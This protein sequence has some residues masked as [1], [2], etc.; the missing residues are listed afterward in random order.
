MKNTKI[1]LLA[2]V[3]VVALLTGVI[4][5]M[6][7]ATETTPLGYSASRVVKKDTTGIT[8]IK[9][10]DTAS[11]KTEYVVSDLDGLNK[12]ATVVTGGK[13]L[14]GVTIYQTANI[15]GKGLG[16]DGANAPFAGIGKDLSKI[17]AGTYDGQGYYVN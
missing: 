13:T 16:T 6:A 4:S 3:M 8:N 2:I 1:K 17:F 11:D 12:L 5:F 14:A 15:S 9:D 10:F 7:F